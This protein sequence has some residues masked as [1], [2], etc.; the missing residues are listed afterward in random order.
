MESITESPPSGLT[1][2]ELR[3]ILA[4][5]ASYRRLLTDQQIAAATVR[6][7]GFPPLRPD[8]ECRG[9]A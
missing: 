7:L 8:T 3:L 9:S 6:M 5:L 1:P 4:L 2:G